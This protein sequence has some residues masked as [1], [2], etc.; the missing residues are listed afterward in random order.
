MSIIKISTFL[1]ALVL[2]GSLIT[3][4]LWGEPVEAQIIPSVGAVVSSVAKVLTTAIM[5]LFIPIIFEIVNIVRKVTIVIFMLFSFTEPFIKYARSII[6]LTIFEYFGEYGYLIYYGFIRPIILAIVLAGVFVI[7]TLLNIIGLIPIVSIP[8]GL[9]YIFS[10]L[11]ILMP[12]AASMIAYFPENNLNPLTQGGEIIKNGF[13]GVGAG[14]IWLLIAFGLFFYMIGMIIPIINLILSI[15]AGII[16]FVCLFVVPI[17]LLIIAWIFNINNIL[18]TLTNYTPI[19]N[20]I[21]RIPLDSINL[22][23]DLFFKTIDLISVFNI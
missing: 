23:Q 13:M 1:M 20:L 2:I 5:D 4:N 9:V 14:V 19:V 16:T 8:A 11:F 15:I 6:G 21:K 3:I 7:G 22:I 18:P 10:I 12:I 17:L